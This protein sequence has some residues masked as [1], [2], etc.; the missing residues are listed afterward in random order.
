MDTTVE[1]LAAA[2]Y[3]Q[4]VA[5]N[6]PGIDSTR[7][8]SER[9]EWNAVCAKCHL[10]DGSGLVGPTVAGNGTM[11]EL[12]S[13][14]QLLLEGQNEPDID[15]YMPAVGSGWADFQFEALLDYIQ[16]NEQLSTPPGAQGGSSG[17]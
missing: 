7:S 13:L 4:W 14:R 5:D 11:L 16:S 8:R 2:E 15:G 3:V 6:E 10:E 1:V 9:I 12:Q 17:G